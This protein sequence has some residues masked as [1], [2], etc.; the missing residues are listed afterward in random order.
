ML[1]QAMLNPAM[2]LPPEQADWSAWNP[3]YK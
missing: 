2:F 1:Y 3:N